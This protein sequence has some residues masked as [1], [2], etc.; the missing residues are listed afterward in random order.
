MKRNKRSATVSH[1]NMP[2]CTNKD[3]VQS[4]TT[5]HLEDN[6]QTRRKK[7]K[8][9]QNS[10]RGKKSPSQS[11]SQQAAHLAGGGNITH[12]NKQSVNRLHQKRKRS[13]VPNQSPSSSLNHEENDIQ[14]LQ[15][16]ED[17]ETSTSEK[18]TSSD[19]EESDNDE[20]II[21]FSDIISS[22][23]NYITGNALEMT[24]F[25]EPVST[26][27]SH[28]IPKSVIKKIQTNKFVH[29]SLLLPN[30][31]LPQAENYSFTLNAKTI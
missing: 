4:R 31:A 18:S 7:S 15:V 30:M 11:S 16:S 3:D 1:C 25:V 21:N 19:E 26:P 8:N 13:T 14:V 29:F 6:G 5:A 23:S 22:H 24:Q 17:E 28:S 9:N 2:C 12:T 27:I 10:H 20:G